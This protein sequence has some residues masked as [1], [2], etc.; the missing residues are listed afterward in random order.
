MEWYKA[1]T[2]EH[3]AQSL[4]EHHAEVEDSEKIYDQQQQ[5]ESDYT[6][7]MRAKRK[8]HSVR[9]TEGRSKSIK[10][11]IV[12]N[13]IKCGREIKQN[14]N[15]NLFFIHCKKEIIMNMEQGCFCGM[16]LSICRLKFGESWKGF[17]VSGKAG[18]YDFLKYFRNKV[19]I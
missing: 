5:I 14:K 3:L 7:R 16:E 1:K 17:K 15:R 8:K 12:I 10:E 6:D 19:E 9:N 18:I 13:G 11:N 4:E 2:I